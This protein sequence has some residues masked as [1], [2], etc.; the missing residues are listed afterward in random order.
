MPITFSFD[1]ER[2]RVHSTVEG[3]V[4][5]H[6]MIEAL[7]SVLAMPEFGPDFQVLSDHRGVERPATV[8]D[9]EDMLAF[10]RASRERF[11]DMR[12]A[13]VTHRPGSYAMMG[14]LSTLADLRVRMQV[15]VFTR[16][17]DATRWLDGE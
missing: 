4:T 12:W 6:E 2:R 8:Q 5:L 15:R 3:T 10:M 1:A 16:V 14:L 7:K 9:V 13:I 11:Q 17:D